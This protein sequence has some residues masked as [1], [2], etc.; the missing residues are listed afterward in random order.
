MLDRRGVFAGGFLGAGLHD[1]Q[2]RH[3]VVLGP[4]LMLCGVVGLKVC[5]VDGS[6]PMLGL[7]VALTGAGIGLCF[8]HIS[9]W[10]MA[11]ARAEEGALTAA[12]IPTIQSLG[13]AFGAAVAGL[14][15][16]AAGLAVGISPTTVS[17]TSFAACSC[18]TSYSRTS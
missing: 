8:A 11:A 15:A 16:N 2:V 13:I 5:V 10:T 18:D 6:L 3:A 9:S 14:M 4:L 1:R 17:A 7:F 12:S